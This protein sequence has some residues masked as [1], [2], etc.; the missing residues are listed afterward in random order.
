MLKKIYYI[1]WLCLTLGMVSIACA[2]TSAAID[3]QFEPLTTQELTQAVAIVKKSPHYSN[4]LLFSLVRLA[5]PTKIAQ[6]TT[7]SITPQR[8]V[9]ITLFN[10]KQNSVYEALVDLNNNTLMTWQAVPNVQPIGGDNDYEL[11]P[12]LLKSNSQWLAALQKRGI[13]NPDEVYVDMWI[14]DASDDPALKN[15]RLVR[16]LPFYLG[17]SQY[18][19]GRPI[20]GLSAIADLTTQKVTVVDTGV[21]PLAKNDSAYDVKSVGTLR[22][23]PHFVHIQ[24]KQ[25]P[26]F[27][28]HDHQITWQ[29]WRFTISFNPRDGV[30]LHNIVYH[31][32]DK[33]RSILD[34]VSLSDILVPYGDPDPQWS[35]RH[36]LDASE[37]GL[38]F[39][40]TPLQKGVDVPENTVFFNMP[41]VEQNGD[42]KQM[43]N[44]VGI[45]EEYGGFVWKHYDSNKT[46][47]NAARRAQNLVISSAMTISN[48]DYIVNYIFKQDASIEVK[49][50]LTGIMLPKGVDKTYHERYGHLVAENIAAPHHQHFF[51]FRLDF[52]VDGRRNWLFEENTSSAPKGPENPMGNAFAH[53]KTL[54]K[55]TLD[56]RRNINPLSNRFWVVFNPN[57]TN[58]L[59]QAVGYALIPGDNTVPYAQPDSAIRQHVGFINYHLWATPYDPKQMNAMGLYPV[60]ASQEDGLAQWA[61]KN[62]S[63]E[64][65]DIVVWY[66]MGITHI[67]RP[68]EWPVMPKAEISFRIIPVGFFNRN[69]AINLPGY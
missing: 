30:T 31:D 11:L 24:Q 14:L 1:T 46:E 32:N 13:K 34:S 66:T 42:I 17:H 51:N 25:G 47:K 38:G 3:R 40:S 10:P 54:L 37:Y 69:P 68:E 64:N 35:W 52:D 19:Y 65:T 61:E 2:A 33:W 60:L 67:P 20:E 4:D 36:A 62:S 48:Y 58:S 22:E 43:P 41:L 6:D 50:I 26:S 53:V 18:M 39:M 29:N 56:A 28:L 7:A 49:V 23:A 12:K 44:A 9:A 45:Y 8:Q 27:Q 57:V 55:N 5:E 21:T 16:G 15:H 59:G 63:L